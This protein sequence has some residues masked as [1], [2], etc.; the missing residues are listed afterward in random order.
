MV[1]S[2]GSNDY[3]AG[4]SGPLEQHPWVSRL[5]PDPNEM[6]ERVTE[7]IG[8]PGDSNRDGYQRLYLTSVLDYYAE[9]ALD[10]LLFTR[11][12]P[13]DSAPFPGHE[14]VAVSLRHE[15]V[16]DYSWSRKAGVLDDFDLDVRF[17]A[18]FNEETLADSGFTSCSGCSLGLSCTYCPSQ[19]HCHSHHCH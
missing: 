13:A 16:I 15:A 19:H 12:V 9:F 8:F 6:P 4:P 10:D 5:R 7:L 1:E 11:T 2:S 3:D 17:R 14:V 18:M